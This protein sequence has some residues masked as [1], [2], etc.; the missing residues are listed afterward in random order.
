MSGVRRDIYW[1]QS[2]TPRACDSSAAFSQSVGKELDLTQTA[3]SLHDT[4]GT[5]LLL[6]G[7]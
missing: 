6:A 7:L 1:V 4:H 2:S 5:L 3:A